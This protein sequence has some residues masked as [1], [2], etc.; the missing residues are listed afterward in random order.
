MKCLAS[1]NVVVM[2]GRIWQQCRHRLG[3]RG[4]NTGTQLVTFN[5]LI[6]PELPGAN[7]ESKLNLVCV[8][9]SDSDKV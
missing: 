5:V 8:A 9:D 3:P 4:Y 7:Y 6:A 2:I 1:V